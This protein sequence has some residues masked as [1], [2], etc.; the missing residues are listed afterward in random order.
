MA[1]GDSQKNAA[2]VLVDA[3]EILHMLDFEG[4]KIHSIRF[5]SSDYWRPD[6]IEILIEHPDLNEVYDGCQLT[7]ITP[8][9]RYTGTVVER[10]KPRKKILEE[11]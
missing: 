7:R 10:V 11:A 3:K 8:E 4:G 5:S 1:F 2:I 6:I 9:Y